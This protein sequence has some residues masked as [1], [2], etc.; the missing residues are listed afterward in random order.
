MASEV[1]PAGVVV[2]SDAPASLSDTPPIVGKSFPTYKVVEVMCN[3]P[4]GSL[5]LSLVFPI[6]VVCVSMPKDTAVDG[7]LKSFTIREHD[8]FKSWEVVHAIQEEWGERLLEPNLALRDSNTSLPRQRP[9]YRVNVQ[10]ALNEDR[11]AAYRRSLLS[12]TF[13]PM[14]DENLLSKTNLEY[15][16][17]VESL[18]ASCKNFRSVC[19]TND[20]GGSASSV[21]D[22]VPPASLTTYFFP[23][24]YV[25]TPPY[26]F[27]NMTG[28]GT[29]YQQP[30]KAVAA[31][32][33]L[34][35][36]IAW[37]VGTG[38]NL[39]A[40]TT[41]MLRTQFTLGWPLAT[42]SSSAVPFNKKVDAFLL[43][44]AD[45]LDREGRHP[46]IDVTYGGDRL[47]EAQVAHETR[48][49][50]YRALAGAAIVVVLS[51]LHT[52]SVVVGLGAGVQMALTFVSSWGLFTTGEETFPLSFYLGLFATV[53]VS[54]NGILT[55]ADNFVHSGI[56]ATTGRANTLSVPQRMSYTFRK[57][58]Q[59]VLFAA[60]VAVVAFMTSAVSPVPAVRDFCEFMA[61]VSSFNLFMCLWYTPS[62]ILVYHFHFSHRRRIL[63]RQREA[64]KRVGARRRNRNLTAFL[65][66]DNSV[67]LRVD[68]PIFAEVKSLPT[69]LRAQQL[70]ERHRKTQPSWYEELRRECCCFGVP[71][72]ETFEAPEQE[73]LRDIQTSEFLDGC[74]LEHVHSGAMSS[75]TWRAT[76]PSRTFHIP[77]T[78][79]SRSESSVVA[80]FEYAQ[81]HGFVENKC[82]E[83]KL[84]KLLA[85][86]SEEADARWQAAAKAIGISGGEL[87]LHI[88]GCVTHLA[89]QSLFG[90]STLRHAVA[91]T[92]PPRSSDQ[93]LK[94]EGAARC[95]CYASTLDWWQAHCNVQREWCCGHCGK[96]VGE[97]A[98]QQDTRILSTRVLHDTYTLA[99]RF[100]FC[101]W[102]TGVHRCRIILSS[103]CVALIIT[104][105]VL[106]SLLTASNGEYTLIDDMPLRFEAAAK[107]FGYERHCDYCSAYYRNPV[108][109]KPVKLSYIDECERQGVA[110]QMSSFIDRCGVCMGNNSCID[111]GGTVSG[112]RTLDQCGQCLAGGSQYNICT[113]DPCTDPNSTL[114]KCTWCARHNRPPASGGSECGKLCTVNANCSR[115][116]P[117]T[118]ECEA[119]GACDNSTCINSTTYWCRGRRVTC[120]A[121]K[122]CGFHGVF[123]TQQEA[124]FV[125]CGCRGHWKGPECQYCACANG[126][127]CT[128]DGECKCPSPWAGH[129]CSA[130]SSS[131]AEN[132]YCPLQ[133]NSSLYDVGT[134]MALY[135]SEDD[136][137]LRRVCDLCSFAASSRLP[138]CATISDD[139]V[140]NSTAGCVWWP[141]TGVC[142][143]THATRSNTDCVCKGHFSG[144][145]CS[146]CPAASSGLF[147]DTNGDVVTCD[148]LLYDDNM[149]YNVLDQCGVCG[150]K[151]SCIGCDGVLGSGLTIDK[152]GVCGGNNSC[153]PGHTQVIITVMWGASRGGG[154]P[155]GAASLDSTVH[156]GSPLSQLDLYH[157]CILLRRSGVA[158]SCL[159][160]DF[161]TSSGTNYSEK[162]FP[163]A[164]Y[165]YAAS[166]RRLP[167]VGFF[168]NV[169]SEATITGVAFLTA[170][171]R[172]YTRSDAD[173][174][175]QLYKEFQVV[176]GVLSHHAMVASKHWISA[177]TSDQA[178][179]GVKWTLG[180]SL[181]AVFFVCCVLTCS[182]TLSACMTLSVTGAC[183]TTL[184]IFYLA[185]LSVDAPMQVTVPILIVLSVECTCHLAEGYLDELQASQSHF[186]AREITRLDAARGSL[187]RSGLAVVISSLAT[188][189]FAL[190]YVRSSISLFA[191]VAALS[192]T[193]AVVAAVFSLIMFISLLCTV[194]PVTHYRRWYTCAFALAAL[195]LVVAVAV[196][197][198]HYAKINGP[199][200]QPLI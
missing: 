94:K 52:R 22:C 127:T 125:G 107:D 33:M 95:A 185:G 74:E 108:E 111:C 192:A 54:L 17:H 37:F 43:D 56:M 126:G 78:L 144:P 145:D 29:V 73:E 34:N 181:V 3:Y 26:A 2:P 175:I 92:C 70:A 124:P 7:S 114:A 113:K 61:V 196:I 197:I 158:V 170:T 21:P 176:E 38:T 66:S 27:F 177:I 180:I 11:L 112:P 28:D 149:K 164:L 16:Q 121:A 40:H 76:V 136:L 160:Y 64:L 162:E 132:G 110:G 67:R 167:E 84:C 23:N 139:A 193:S 171:V 137:S 99:E 51:G 15:V 81:E 91:V 57:A 41:K 166:Q 191:D 172:R 168:G 153:N 140:C 155:F 71:T 188:V 154:T 50:L 65:A 120:A 89:F 102:G 200:V 179:E 72:V 131:C 115:C 77:P 174:M 184:A 87:V 194:G 68:S 141:L 128:E 157:D 49:E 187:L 101:F 123:Y 14:E 32:M 69:A 19:W 86:P 6:I 20:K 165:R 97:T 24:G 104:A 12:G 105:A 182:V 88:V 119:N 103:L 75:S 163:V 48:H 31:R 10:F 45:K 116:N 39:T 18:A 25:R 189:T 117:Y 178:T 58:G 190:L 129:D 85:P 82:N 118:A 35:P 47:V 8:A 5:V 90:E 195:L 44:F 138:S 9:M 109:Y 169:E 146:E 55:F 122:A 60:V 100:I 173:S 161:V 135:C 46:Y 150:G 96:R 134:C 130:C 142:T 199:N 143:V 13:D 98:T 36:N 148:G 30:F 80:A 53:M 156:L 4:V 183:L 186:F 151:G 93:N 79:C 83:D 152:C 147:C 159:M 63:Q 1:R 133:W 42:G 106:T 198:I 59:G 62:L